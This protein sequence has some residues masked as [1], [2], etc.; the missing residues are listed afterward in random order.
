MKSRVKTISFDDM[1]D[2]LADVQ[3]R[4][5]LLALVEHNP[6][7]D[8]PVVLADSEGEA[9]A[10]NRLVSMR[11]VHLPKLADYG[12]IEWDEATHELTKGPQFDAIRP[13]LT[14]LDDHADELPDD[15]V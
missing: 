8:T 1:L 7:V 3:R 10:M 14:L 4:T 9:A 11:H 2:A 13:L 15:W 6:Q 12:L 5:L